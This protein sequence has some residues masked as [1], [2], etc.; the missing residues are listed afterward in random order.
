MSLEVLARIAEEAI[1]R[2]RQH[3]R[4]L[5]ADHVPFDELVGRPMHET[6]SARALS[7]DAVPVGVLGPRGGGKSSLIAYVSKRLPNTHVA[8][9]VPVTGADDPT[10]VSNVAVVA[11]GQALSDLDLEAQQREALEGARADTGTAARTPAGVRGGTLGGGPI[12]AQLNAELG[13]LRVELTTGRL[14]ADRLAGLDRLVSILVARQLEPVFVLE[15]TEAALGGHDRT[16]AEAFFSG[17]VRAFVQEVEAPCVI[18]VQDTFDGLEAFTRLAATMQLVTIPALE[19]QGAR[20][21]LQAIIANRLDQHRIPPADAVTTDEALDLLVDFYDETGRDIRFTM[22]ALQAAAEY[23][24]ERSA[25]VIEGA[26]LRAAA[27]DW[28]TRIG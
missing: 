6:R 19:G 18:A 7:G 15:D 11:L 21:A 9:R 2:P 5:A 13:S 17:P 14:A 23:A 25:E 22:A 10:S 28:R 24:S 4:Q 27:A 20:D 12:P 1:F 26:D 8:L 3:F 16:L